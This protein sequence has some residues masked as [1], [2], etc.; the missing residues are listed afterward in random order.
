[1]EFEINRH[2]GE[3]KGYYPTLECKGYYPT[4]ISNN[5]SIGGYYPYI[6]DYLGIP[7]EKYVNYMKKYGARSVINLHRGF[8]SPVYIFNNCNDCQNFIKSKELESY[9]IMCKLME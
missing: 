2:K 4:L 6:A 3:C 9:L 1:M 5:I 7:R 8:C